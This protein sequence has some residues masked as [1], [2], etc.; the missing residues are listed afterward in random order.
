MKATFLDFITLLNGVFVGS[1]R[2][3]A[4]AIGSVPVDSLYCIVSCAIIA[5]LWKGWESVVGALCSRQRSSSSERVVIRRGINREIRTHQGSCP[6]K[7]LR[8]LDLDIA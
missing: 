4:L 1:S 8:D 7:V 6:W 5:R 2:S 3:I